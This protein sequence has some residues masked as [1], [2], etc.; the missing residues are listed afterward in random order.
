LDILEKILA[1]INNLPT[2]PT[3][4]STLSEAI[5]DPN[6]NTEKLA[7][8]ISTDQV[9]S[10][11]ILK[12]AN[13]PFYG[14][15]GKIDT[16]TQAILYLGFREVKNIVFAITVINFFSKDKELSRF[17]PVDYWAHSIGVGIATRM[18]GSI[19]RETKIENYFLAGIFHDIGKLLFSEFAQKEYSKVLEI[20]ARNNCLIRD[21]EV[22]VFGIEHSKVGQI[23]SEK[24][25]LPL[26]IQNAIYYHH[27]GILGQTKDKL[28]ASVHVGDIIARAMKLGYP[29]D[30]LI[31]EPNIKV[32]EILNIPDGAI[33]SLRKSLRSDFEQTVHLM[34]VD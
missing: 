12:V 8:I 28:I 33:T 13:S 9:S 10:L 20:V 11:K 21:A 3:I 4:Y 29:G 30:T 32:W 15:N 14:F 1:G 27:E 34:L 19:A 22:E 24:W 6:T 2:L 5:E 18:I 31:P 25:K 7:K 23:L 16:I 17:R 26:S